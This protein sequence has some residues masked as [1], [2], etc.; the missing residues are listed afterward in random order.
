MLGHRPD[1]VPFEI[2]DLGELRAGERERL[3][4][5]GVPGGAPC[6][7]RARRRV[8]SVRWRRGCARRRG[9]GSW[10]CWRRR[11]GRASRHGQTRRGRQCRSSGL[12][13]AR[14][15]ATGCGPQNEGR[16]RGGRPRAVRRHPARSTSAARTS[17]ATATVEAPPTRSASRGPN[18]I[19]RVRSAARRAAGRWRAGRAPLRDARIGAKTAA[20]AMR[21]VRR[22]AEEGSSAA[23]AHAAGHYPVGSPGCGMRRKGS[24][25][26]IGLRASGGKGFSNNIPSGESNEQEFGWLVDNPRKQTRSA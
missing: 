23:S 16:T 3:D 25:G 14:K 26:K 17:V 12:P 5:G 11:R 6:A 19:R 18:Q 21:H 9:G 13:A 4:R 7:G 24:G 10:R 22:R 20:D 15:P 1:L 8:A 2:E